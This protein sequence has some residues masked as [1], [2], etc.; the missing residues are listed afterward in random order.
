MTQTARQPGWDK[1]A[2][3]QIARDLYDGLDG[4]FEAHGWTTDGRVISQ[5][6]PTKVVQTYGSVDSFVRAHE[7]GVAG[8]AMLDP[9]AAILSDPPDVWIKSF[10]G[11]SPED[12][13]FL[14]YSDPWKVDRF[15][16]ES[17]SKSL[18]LNNLLI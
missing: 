2:I 9:K 12:W 15:L 3:N 16:K 5:I 18:D 8:N 4:M 1:Q 17:R 14:G 13:G 10:Y 7:G 6:A 11:F